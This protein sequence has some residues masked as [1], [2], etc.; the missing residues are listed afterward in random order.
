MTTSF[1]CRTPY[2]VTRLCYR[3]IMSGRQCFCLAGSGV[4]SG[5]VRGA[6]AWNVGICARG[7]ASAITLEVPGICLI[8]TV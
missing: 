6:N 3:W 2:T 5:A 4:G 7:N 1:V 8:M